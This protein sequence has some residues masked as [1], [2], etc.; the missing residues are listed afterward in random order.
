MDTIK[1]SRRRTNAQLDEDVM[2][3]LGELIKQN[4]FGNVD[5]TALTTKANIGANVFYRRYGTMQKMYDTLASKYDFWINDTVELT[6]LNEVGPKVFFAN[7]LK[8]LFKELSDNEIMQK[9]LLWELSDD[10]STTRRTAQMRDTMNLHIV[11]FYDLMFR[12]VKIS[13]RGVIAILISGTYYLILHKER[14][15]FCSI[16]FNSAEGEKEFS[17]AIDFLTDLIFDRLD[18]YREKRE[19]ALRMLD[20]GL[21]RKKICKYMNISDSELATLIQE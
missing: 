13:I 15:E 2:R 20:D 10:N 16:D 1:R 14:A 8:S 3:E 11:Q 7:T 4:G 19:M 6:K 5:L 9:L 12:P 18:L 21:S 17:E